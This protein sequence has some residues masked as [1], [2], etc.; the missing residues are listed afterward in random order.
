MSANAE[1]VFEEST[2]P[3]SDTQL[4]IGVA[5]PSGSG[6]TNSMLRLATG[7]QRETGGDI[8]VVDTER[9]RARHYDKQFKFRHLNFEPPFSPMDY[10]AAFE[11][12]RKKGARIIICD[13]ASPLHEGTGGILEWH[14]REVDRIKQAWN[15]SEEKANVPAWQKPKTALREFIDYFTRLDCHLLF[16]FKA[17]EKLKLGG[18]KVTS[19]GFMPIMS[20][21]LVFELTAKVLLLPGAEGIPTLESSE[22][23]EKMMI[24]LP[25]YLRPIFTG[26]AKK[27]LD[28]DI[29]QQLAKWAAGSKEQA[30]TASDY[31]ACANLVA[32]EALEK[33]RA[34]AWRTA[35]NEQK[36][37]LKKAS[38]AAKARLT[39]PASNASSTEREP[40]TEATAIAALEGCKTEPHRAEVWK[41]INVD[42]NNNP[43]LNVEAKAKEMKEAL[44]L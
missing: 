42:F 16:G 20:E 44:A 9:N 39:P 25:G 5:G 8:W 43:P 2:G 32:F 4:L 33:R 41:L 13:S 3:R 37:E 35:S 31:E 10:T 19:L 6:K 40:F 7:I 12:C 24:K 11:H 21:E 17:R 30:P 14:G 34:V 38:D 28:E 15:C 1:R 23:G 18:G 36:N 27:A 26:A 29:G 22:L